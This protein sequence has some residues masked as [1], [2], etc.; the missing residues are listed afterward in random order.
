[1]STIVP[2]I[3]QMVQ[4]SPEWL[5]YRRSMRNAS[6][7]TAVLGL[8]PWMSPY[9]LW[10]FKTGRAEPVAN[11]AMTHGTRLEPV[12]RAAYETHTGH[13]MQP[14]VI[15]DQDGVY[16]ASL[17]GMVL[18]GSL[19]LEVKCPFHGQ[20]SELWQQAAAGEVPEHYQ[21]QIQHQLM[22]SGAAKAHFWVYGDGFGTLVE[23]LPNPIW[24]ARIQA[25][26]EAFQ[27]HLDRDTPPALSDTDTRLRNDPEWI[28]AAN[29][30]L[31]AKKASD[32]ASEASEVV[33]QRLLALAEHPKELGAGV[34]VT[35]YW[36]QGNVD[37]K[38]VPQLAG[39]ELDNFR[40]TGRFDVRVSAL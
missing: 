3:V 15:Q 25:G 30:F 28:E 31:V 23:V 10:L 38:K 33:R 17:D 2:N 11:A 29:A 13:V 39:V 7:S 6:E 22:V 18:D 4:G 16:S 8:S 20:L 37:Y 21:C 1:M 9:Q 34:S 24:M 36:R 35:R 26:W 5:A 27:V 32:E 40:G 12:A 19:I 14:L